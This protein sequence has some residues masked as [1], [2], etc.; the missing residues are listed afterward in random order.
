MPAGLRGAHIDQPRKGSRIEAHA[1]D[2]TG[3]VLSDSTPV[4][5][6]EVVHDGS[7]VRRVPLDWM[8]DDVAEA[9]SD[10][11]HAERSGFRTTVA[12]I[13]P[14]AELTLEVR[15]VLADQRRVAIGTVRARRAWR[16]G[17]RAGAGGLVSVVIP[18]HNQA[19]FLVEA[20][21]S[22]L[23]QTYADFEV[24]VVDDGSTDNTAAVVKQFPGV[25]YVHQQNAGAPAARNAGLRNTTGA[26]LV[27][28]DADDRLLPDALQAGLDCFHAHSECGFVFGSWRPIISDG[29]VL[30]ARE[31]PAP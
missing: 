30:P 26:Y 12:F 21:E 31:P 16:D 14:T 11:A 17:E 4:L 6:V 23:A 27:F 24:V 8:R 19:H 28:L 13:G 10:V 2:I 1:V 22:V 9:F 7:V 18:C 29:S 3:W 25:G 5:S 20:I 15:A